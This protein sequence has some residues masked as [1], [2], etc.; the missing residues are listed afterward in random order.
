MARSR[1][2]WEKG[3]SGNPETQ[4]KPGERVPGGWRS[5][6]RHLA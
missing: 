1:T 3:H 4:W 6:P 2:T 5:H